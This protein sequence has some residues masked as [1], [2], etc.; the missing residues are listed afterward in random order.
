MRSVSPLCSEKLAPQ[1]SLELGD[2]LEPSQSEEWAQQPSGGETRSFRGP[3]T[4]RVPWGADRVPSS[5]AGGSPSHSER[6]ARDAPWAHAQEAS[7]SALGTVLR[8]RGGAC[9]RLRGCPEP[10]SSSAA[11]PASAGKG[12]W[13]WPPELG[14]QRAPDLPL[15]PYPLQDLGSAGR[16]SP[17]KES[18]LPTPF[19]RRLVM[20][21]LLLPPPGH[22]ERAGGA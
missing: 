1:G 21:L 16:F 22:L 3:D 10:E 20:D 2:T 7:S 6:R 5:S 13:R 11:S 18:S 12:E 14:T 9:W 19:P 4:A 17:L 8:A 15:L